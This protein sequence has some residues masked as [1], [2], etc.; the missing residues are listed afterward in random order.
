MLKKPV[1]LFTGPLGSGKTTLLNQLIPL[2]PAPVA[3]IEN[4]F[5]EIN[6]D[7]QILSSN[8]NEDI[9]LEMLNGCLCCSIKTDLIQGLRRLTEK[10]DDFSALFIES[11]GLADPGP[12]KEAFLLDP[13]LREQFELKLVVTLIDGV[14]FLKQLD[15]ADPSY[16]NIIHSQLVFADVFY[17]SK[18]DL[19]DP[20]EKK[21]LED[22]A[23]ALNPFALFLEDLS[24]VPNMSSTNEITPSSKGHHHP[25]LSSLAIEFPGVINHS[26]LEMFLST[27]VMRYR[28]ELYR[29]KGVIVIK[30]QPKKVFFQ[31]VYETFDFELGGDWPQNKKEE[32]RLNQFVFIGKNL[33]KELIEKGLKQCLL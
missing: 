11:T 24:L 29:G 4:E 31:N 23:T 6:I 16:K 27:L 21:K 15:E 12:I 13:V 33:N 19:V 20:Q 30:S 22:K 5:G 10:K 18:K 7:S 26:L 8:K 3:L 1:Y 2:F 28:G 25:E 9:Y 32:E 14:H 17:L